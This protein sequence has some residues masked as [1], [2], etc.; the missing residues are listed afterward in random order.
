M[1]LETKTEKKSGFSFSW[2]LVI[3]FCTV[4]GIMFFQN[5]KDV[6]WNFLWHEGEIPLSL[7]ITGVFSLGLFLGLS[8]LLPGRWRLYRANK[9]LKNQIEENK[10]PL[11]DSSYITINE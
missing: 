7:L 1:S 3:V 5:Q 10:K 6:Y 2:I 9:K 8:L 11:K 4:F